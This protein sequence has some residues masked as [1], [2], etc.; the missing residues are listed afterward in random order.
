MHVYI[1][2]TIYSCIKKNDHKSFLFIE[3]HFHSDLIKNSYPNEIGQNPN[4]S[5][6]C[7][8]FWMLD[9]KANGTQH[10]THSNNQIQFSLRLN[11]NTYA[12]RKS[13]GDREGEGDRGSYRRGH[14]F[15]IECCLCINLIEFNWKCQLMWHTASIYANEGGE[16]D[17]QSQSIESE[18]EGEGS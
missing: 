6:S 3:F 1:W 9:A 5:Q 4:K 16:R 13:E 2:D 11:F 18:R 15:V 8:S 12:V 7:A 14:R 17:R 10:L